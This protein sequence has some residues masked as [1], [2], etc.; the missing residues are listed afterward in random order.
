MDL[1]IVESPTKAKTLGRFLGSGYQVAASMGHVRDLPKKELGV[2]VENKFTPTYAVPDKARKAVRELTQKAK[3]AD[4][5]YLATDPDRE[6]EAIGWHIAELLR[7][8][9]KV[10]KKSLNR[11]VFHEITKEAVTQA[12][13]KPG[14]INLQLVDAQQARRILDRLVGYQ[15]SPLLWKKVRGGLSAGRV[16][17][18]AVRLVV[19]RERE[20]EAFKPEEYWVLTTELTPKDRPREQFIALLTKKAAKKIKIGDQKTAAAVKADL[21]AAAYTITNLEKSQRRLRPYP[22][23]ITSTLQRSAINLYGMSAKRAMRAAQRLYEAGLITYHRT[24]SLNLSQSFIQSARK[25]ILTTY[26]Q[27]YLP[28]KA[29]L[30]KTKAKSAQEAHEAIRPTAVTRLEESLAAVKQN[31]GRDEARI[32]GLVWQRALASQ[33]MPAVFDETQVKI[34]AAVKKVS[35]ELAAKGSVRR[36]DGWQKV[37]ERKTTADTEGAVLPEL[38]VKEKLKLIKVNADQKFTQ[39]PARYTEASLIKALESHGIGRPSTYAPILST[40]QSRGYVEREEK[41]LK[42]GDVGII[43][44]DLLVEHFPRIVD[45]D[46]T[47]Q[48]E[49]KLD[50]IAHGEIEWVPVVS[51]FYEPFAEQL[52]KATKTV[53]RAEVT[54]FEKLPEK[55]PECGGQLLVKLGKYGK[56]I[57]C[58][59]YPQCDYSRPVEGDGEEGIDKSQIKKACP[60]CGSELI[61]KEGRFG[62]FIACTGYPKCK[63]TEPYLDKTGMKCPECQK[64]EVIFKKTKKGRRFYGCSAYPKCKFAS[65]R[66][67]KSK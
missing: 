56:F 36:F 15:L 21:E 41:Q 4:H 9:A 59:K 30:Y 60:E 13:K 17:S 47:A 62:K 34:E 54:V 64:G 40:I 20:R 43:V 57:S 16:Q 12:F 63:H 1:V 48:L 35:Y 46:F 65:W 52:E 50:D 67:P 33:M 44:N 22:P 10:K 28:E 37:M 2:D 19:E 45:I 25:F 55:C 27:G 31:L 7:S 39:P 32:Y 66:K 49:E 29:N 51:E 23:L 14:Q 11:V 24:D 3:K 18:V 61:V 5:V 42:P 53:D 26:G 58:E 6:G 38:A 8:Q